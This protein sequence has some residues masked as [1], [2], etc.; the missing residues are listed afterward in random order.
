MVCMRV[1]LVEPSF[2][3]VTDGSQHLSTYCQVCVGSCSH[4]LSHQ[5]MNVIT[6]RGSYVG[7]AYLVAEAPGRDD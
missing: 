3:I 2:W 6:P 5:V 7:H 4:I 1:S